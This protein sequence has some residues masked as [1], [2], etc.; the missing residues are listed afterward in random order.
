M[1]ASSTESERCCQRTLRVETTGSAVQQYI[2]TQQMCRRYADSNATLGFEVRQAQGVDRAGAGG[3]RGQAS[4]L[5]A[6]IECAALDR[7]HGYEVK[8]LCPKAAMLLMS[9]YFI[10]LRAHSV[11][12]V[13]LLHWSTTHAKSHVICGS[14]LIHDVSLTDS[15]FAPFGAYC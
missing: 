5:G 15:L 14:L 13:S 1:L 8:F 7:I 11:T 9:P 3:D 10:G 2:R 12:A 6:K 4:F